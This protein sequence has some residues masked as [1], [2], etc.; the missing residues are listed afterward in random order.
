VILPLI[1]F[2]VAL[3]FI[4]VVP[5]Y[6]QALRDKQAFTWLLLTGI[7]QISIFLIVHLSFLEG[8]LISSQADGQIIIPLIISPIIVGIILEVIGKGKASNSFSFSKEKHKQIIRIVC[9]FGITFLAA[10]CVDVIVV[11]PPF[12]EPMIHVFIGAAGLVD[13]LL[14]APVMSVI[15]YEIIL[16]LREIL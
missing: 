13:G 9:L 10:F 15:A 12:S 7:L 8:G 4:I 11:L 16:S 6:K 5:K 2:V 1:C 3:V 14:W